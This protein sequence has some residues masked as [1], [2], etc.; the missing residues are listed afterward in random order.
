MSTSGSQ[1]QEKA[2]ILSGRQ[3]AQSCT[4]ANSTPIDDEVAALGYYSIFVTGWAIF[5][6]FACFKKRDFEG[7]ARR[8]TLECTSVEQ[9]LSYKQVPFCFNQRFISSLPLHT[10]LVLTRSAVSYST[11]DFHTSDGTTGNLITGAYTLPDGQVGNLYTGPNPSNTAAAAALTTA[12]ASAAAPVKMTANAASTVE[13]MPTSASD[14]PSQMVVT[15][16]SM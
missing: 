15:S 10:L 4:Y 12:G 8:A 13:S 7:V 6:A 11:Y 3:T 16:A 1:L 9:C 5:C 2:F 14:A